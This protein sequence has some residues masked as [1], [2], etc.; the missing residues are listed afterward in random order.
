MTDTSTQAKLED[1]SV[2]R[3]G[4]IS[5]K[6]REAL[7][8]SLPAPA[9]Q[10][11]TVMIPGKVVDFEASFSEFLF[12]PSLTMTLGISGARRQKQFASYQGRAC[13]STTLR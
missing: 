13:A 8:K 6:I 9:E 5:T 1:A 7:R 4:E 12:I 10:F 11:F 3:A 2:K